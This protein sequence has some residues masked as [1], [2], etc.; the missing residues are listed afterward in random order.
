M[1]GVKVNL[2]FCGRYGYYCY[3]ITKAMLE[4]MDCDGNCDECEGVSYHG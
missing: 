3:E 4:N 1:G 2:K